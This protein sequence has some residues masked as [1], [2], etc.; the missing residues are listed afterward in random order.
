MIVE[1]FYRHVLFVSFKIITI[2]ILSMINED[3]ESFAR[4]SLLI[5][6]RPIADFN[7]WLIP[8]DNDNDY[9]KIS[10]I[11][12]NMIIAGS[13]LILIIDWFQLTMIIQRF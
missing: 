12:I 2:T 4:S 3:Y 9:L 8:I 1:Q 10:G 13:P 7:Y 6:F 11:Y 5:Y